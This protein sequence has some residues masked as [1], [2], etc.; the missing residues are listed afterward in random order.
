VAGLDATRPSLM[1]SGDE[2][3]HVGV[4]MSAAATSSGSR[5]VNDRAI[6]FA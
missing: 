5:T 2:V 3:E 1:R 6:F 4:L